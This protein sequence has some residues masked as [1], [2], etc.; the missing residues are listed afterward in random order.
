M[1]RAA[2][3]E[4]RWQTPLPATVVGSWGPD[5]E[6]W[7]WR[8][9]GIT[10]DRWQRRAL[11]RA[12]A[13]DL[14]FRLV[15]R[16]Y[17][18][19]TARQNG[20]TAL[21]RA[22]IGWALTARVIPDWS[23]IAGLAHD[24]TQARI[25]YQAV[26]QDL[27]PMARRLGPTS[28]GGLNLTRYLG[29]RS[30]TYGRHREYQ[31]YSREARNAIRGTS[32]DLVLFDELRTQI[33]DETWMAVE[34]TTTAR[35]DP[36]IVGISTAGSERSVLLRAWFD[37]GLRIIEGAEPAA[38]FGMTWYAPADTADP[39]DPRTW[40]LANPSIA[41]R[42]MDPQRIRDAWSALTPAAFR[43]ERLNLWSDAQDA[44]LPPGVWAMTTRGQPE[45]ASRPIVAVEVSPSWRR[46]TVTVAWL[47]DA[48]AWFGIA[49][50]L[51]ASR[52]AAATVDPREISAMLDRVRTSWQPAAIAY[53][54]AAAAAPTVAAWAESTRTRQVALGAREIR[55]ACELFRGELVGGRLGHADDPVL[56]AQMRVARP[57]TPIEGGGWF[58]SVRESSGEIDAIR[59]AAWASWAAIAPPER[60]VAPQIFLGKGPRAPQ[61]AAEAGPG[62]KLTD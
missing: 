38:G 49:D 61:T 24:K 50:E 31:T 11:N 33:D 51:D 45:L 18:I 58:F 3:P 2:Y 9:L 15:H 29:L 54:S 47:T 62:P 10:L 40:T 23:A 6:A 60:V 52:T 41:D 36:L 55:A 19:S 5:V 1:S 48:G 42:R 4:P 32:N 13:Y 22:L 17:L 39:L 21:V 44:W 20:K 7:A 57:N 43:M 35:P 8:E 26:A 59:S 16:I 12:L 14:S 30:E 27:A 28:R 56:G 25:P 46:A 53:S 37:R 34:P